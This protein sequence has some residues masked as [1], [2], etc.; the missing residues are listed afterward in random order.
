MLMSRFA[1]ILLS[2]KLHLTK[3]SYYTT[4]NLFIVYT[5]TEIF[6]AAL[7]FF[8][9]PTSQFLRADIHLAH[10][11]ASSKHGLQPALHTL[12]FPLLFLVH[13]PTTPFFPFYQYYGLWLNFD[14]GNLYR[15]KLSNEDFK[16][17]LTNN[18]SPA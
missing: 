16:G 13:N 11:R 4:P 1:Y 3:R 15:I 9:L 7:L 2:H 5:V 8:V 10:S 17:K 14:E 6:I 18:L 12:R